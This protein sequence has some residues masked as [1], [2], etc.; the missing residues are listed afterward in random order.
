[1]VQYVCVAFLL[2]FIA[3]KNQLFLVFLLCFRS[4]CKYQTSMVLEAVDTDFAGH[5]L[6]ESPACA[7]WCGS[8]LCSPGT[9]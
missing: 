3:L 2:G 5:D 9:L 7:V 4:A 6:A 1:M 8:S